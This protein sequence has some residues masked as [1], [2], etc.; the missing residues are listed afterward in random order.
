MSIECTQP[1]FSFVVLYSILLN[2]R[3]RP[4]FF[5]WSTNKDL[6]RSVKRHEMPHSFRKV[7]F[8]PAPHAVK[9][10][11][12]SIHKHEPSL[13]YQPITMTD[14]E[15]VWF[16]GAHCGMSI[17]PLKII[18]LKRLTDVGG[19][20]VANGTRNSLA[21]IPLRWMVK[22]CFLANTGIM[23]Y[24]SMFKQIG[25][26]EAA[27][28]LDGRRPPPIYQ[29]PCPPGYSVPKPRVVYPMDMARTF[30]SEE[31]EDLA[32]AL[33]PLHDQLKIKWGW[34]TLEF[35]PQVLPY[36]RNKDKRWERGFV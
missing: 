5:T 17:T 22:Q 7:P 14:V 3:F 29:T 32:D 4:N 35:I 15:E 26:D 27:L 12:D 1:L 13:D 33:C 24:R 8:P 20:S 6:K 36:Q 16:A 10:Y 31:Q 28:H 25:M 2:S 18:E 34:W 11:T 30:V 9:Q 21:R 19:G 23:F